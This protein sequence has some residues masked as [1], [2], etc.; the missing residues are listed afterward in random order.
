VERCIAAHTRALADE[1]LDSFP[2]NA[3]HF[4]AAFHHAP[5]PDLD[6]LLRGLSIIDRLRLS[7]HQVNKDQGYTEGALARGLELLLNVKSLETA[8]PTTLD[9]ELGKFRR[10]TLELALPYAGQA[11]QSI[12]RALGWDSLLPFENL[13]SDIARSNVPNLLQQDLTNSDDPESGLIDR[14]AL[15]EVIAKAQPDL[16]ERYLSLLTASRRPVANTLKYVSA[17]LGRDRNALEKSVSKHVQ[18]A[19]KAYGLL[20]A[21][22]DDDVLAR[23]MTFK[24][25]AR[26]ATRHGAERTRNTLAAVQVGLAHLA[27]A[28]GY[29]DVAHLEWTMEAHVADE[30]S[31]LNGTHQV[32]AWQVHISLTGDEPSLSVTKAGKALKA[33]PPA[34]RKSELYLRYKEQEAL[35]QGQTRRFRQCFETMMCT[36]ALLRLHDLRA[37]LKLSAARSMISRLVLSSEGGVLGFLQPDDLTLRDADGHTQPLGAYVRIAHPVHMLGASVLPALQQAVVEAR[38]MQP[39]KQVFRELYLLTQAEREAVTVSNRFAR[40]S[41]R[42][43]VAAKLLTTRGWTIEGGSIVSVT[44]ALRAHGLSAEL[45]LESVGRYFSE[46]DANVTGP[47]SFRSN[48]G[49]IPLEQVPAHVFSEVM[50]DVDLV[51]SVAHGPGVSQPFSSSTVEHRAVLIDALTRELGLK[52]VSTEAPFVHVQG[53]RASYRIHLGSGAVHLEPRKSS[54]STDLVTP[55]QHLCIIPV[56]NAQVQRIF[57]PFAEPDLATSVIVSKVLL[58]VADDE[59]TDAGILAQLET[60]LA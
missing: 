13:I 6:W 51:V 21:E 18:V 5:R 39:F 45:A 44:K 57:L 43:A 35:L 54:S 41:F 3:L 38:I 7:S 20:P 52:T 53:T 49:V 4:S 22:G 9:R 58:L 14:G 36:G 55:G 26:E 50:R 2:E 11:R 37:L 27:Q 34:L 17:V 47:V 31:E 15:L 28:A 1:W 8:Q 25:I 30:A 33:V 23:F 48:S 42:G 56:S 46:L 24:R 19:I 60:A 59:I 29:P 16:L 10:E 32:E 40:H 12:L